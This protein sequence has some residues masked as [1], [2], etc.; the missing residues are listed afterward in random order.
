MPPKRKNP[1]IVRSGNS[2]NSS[3]SATPATKPIAPPSGDT[4]AA[5]PSVSAPKPQLF[6]P[7]SKTPLALLNERCQ[8]QSWEKPLVDAVRLPR[9]EHLASTDA[10]TMPVAT[11]R[12]RLHCGRDSAEKRSEGDV[13][14]A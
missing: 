7:G 1:Q 5:G 8:K 9:F 11:T 3:R 2:G 14:D 4:G 12:Q 13:Q 10:R 6:P